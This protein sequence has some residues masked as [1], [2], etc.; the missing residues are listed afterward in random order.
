MRAQQLALLDAFGEHTAELAEVARIATAW[1]ALSIDDLATLEELHR[2]LANSGQLLQGC[3]TLAERLDGDNEFALLRGIARTQAEI[4]N[5]T[6]HEARQV[7]LS[8]M[9]KE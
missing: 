9:P 2:R 6:R 7:P 1:R 3:A 8:E 5:L 4:A